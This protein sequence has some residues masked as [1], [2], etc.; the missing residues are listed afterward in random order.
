MSFARLHWD[1]H[2]PPFPIPLLRESTTSNE[3]K[4]RHPDICV[5]ADAAHPYPATKLSFQP[6][7]LS[8]HTAFPHG[9]L[10]R[11]DSTTRSSNRSSTGT[12]NRARTGSYASLRSKEAKRASWGAGAAMG[13]SNSGDRSASPSGPHLSGGGGDSGDSSSASPYH[14]ESAAQGAGLPDFFPDR[15]LLASS[16]DCLRIW[17]ISR[18]EAYAAS[19]A[20]EARR[21]TG[22][23]SSPG[24]TGAGRRR[25]GTGGGG[26]SGEQEGNMRFELGEKSVLAHVSRA[27]LPLFALGRDPSCPR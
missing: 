13:G 27:G 25:P 6:S 14:S 3:T 8:A 7:T 9:L 19:A 17:E 15:E 1:S 18:N 10:L 4:K 2:P 23:V 12:A 22:F 5:L 11:E 20:E 16:A 26:G 24:S 21:N